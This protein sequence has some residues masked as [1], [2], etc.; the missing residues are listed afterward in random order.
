MLAPHLLR[1][2]EK[3]GI[4]VWYSVP[5]VLVAMLN[6]GGFETHCLRSV[7]TV[8][9]AGDVFPTPQL[10]RLRRALP[11]SRLVN[12]FG[13]TET[14]VCTYYEVP[15]DIPDERT[16]SIPIGKGCEHLETFVITDQG[17]EADVGVEGTLWV[18]GGNLMQGYWNDPDRTAGTLRPDPRGHAGTACCTGDRV[19]LLP[20]GNYE[21]LG[22]RDD[23][24][25]VRGYPVALGEIESVLTT[26]PEVIEAAARRTLRG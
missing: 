25:K 3:W 4:T 1:M 24:V 23:M 20:D 13:P 9:F 15:L 11:D 5:S 19:R 8:L 12:L 7:R 14:N 6:V 26:H 18:K 2:I 21:F 22:R 10:R 16:S 17:C